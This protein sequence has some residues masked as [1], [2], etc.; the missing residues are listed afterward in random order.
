MSLAYFQLG[1]KW[2]SMGR[3]IYSAGGLRGFTTIIFFATYVIL[4]SFTHVKGE[5]SKGG[6]GI[7]SP[8]PPKPPFSVSF[9]IIQAKAGIR[10]LPLRY[11]FYSIIRFYRLSHCTSDILILVGVK[12][13]A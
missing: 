7:H 13:A 9:T 6:V 3:I 12:E 10:L 8:V 2:Y 1:Y 5:E 4:Q 11:S